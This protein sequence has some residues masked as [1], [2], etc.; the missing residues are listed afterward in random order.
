MKVKKLKE[1][2][3]DF[4]FKDFNRIGKM[5]DDM[6]SKRS[7]SK[8]LWILEEILTIKDIYSFWAFMIWH[9]KY[10]QVIF[11]QTPKGLSCSIRLFGK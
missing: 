2:N 1:N 9:I 5:H 10:I 6:T 7:T 8:Q 3:Y 11:L 4:L